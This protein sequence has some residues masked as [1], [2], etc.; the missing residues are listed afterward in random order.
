MKIIILIIL[1]DK[2]AIGNRRAHSIK[3]YYVLAKSLNGFD[4]LDG[5]EMRQEHYKRKDEG[6][7]V[8]FSR[9]EINLTDQQKAQIDNLCD[10]YPFND[11]LNI[12]INYDFGNDKNQRKCKKIK[13]YM[14][15]YYTINDKSAVENDINYV[16]F[17]HEDYD[18]PTHKLP[19]GTEKVEQLYKYD[20]GNIGKETKF[21]F[22]GYYNNIT[23]KYAKFLQI[24]KDLG[25]AFKRTTK[26][27]EKSNIVEIEGRIIAAFPPALFSDYKHN[28][29]F[30][31]STKNMHK[32]SNYTYDRDENNNKLESKHYDGSSIV[33]QN[34]DVFKLVDVVVEYYDDNIDERYQFV[35]PFVMIDPKNIHLDFYKDSGIGKFANLTDNRYGQVEE[36]YSHFNSN[37]HN[38]SDGNKILDKDATRWCEYIS[39]I[40][41]YIRNGGDS[42]EQVHEDLIKII[43]GVN[44]ISMNQEIANF[45]IISMRLYNSNYAVAKH[46]KDRKYKLNINKWINIRNKI[47]NYLDGNNS[48]AEKINKL[49]E[50]KQPIVKYE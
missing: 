3:S 11:A 38:D 8:G 7:V 22:S 50:E 26:I 33:A 46:I 20:A 39:P 17:W 10:G 18:K 27:A 47:D 45:R 1:L 49:K 34:K 36:C 40:E 37:Y 12:N 23:G 4:L 32:Y 24:Y 35:V 21:T 13:E 16:K 19:N 43:C 28:S 44:D 29:Q 48:L 31:K 42:K 41:P 2:W 30:I 15:S 5:N 6:M 14:Y 25:G 9:T